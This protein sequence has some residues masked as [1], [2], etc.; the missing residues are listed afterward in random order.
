MRALPLARSVLVGALLAVTGGACSDDSEG[1]DTD[2]ALDTTAATGMGLPATAAGAQLAWVVT[3]GRTAD[4]A[5]ITERFS[6]GF[7]DEVP[8]DQLRSVLEGLG[9]LTAGEVRTS[10]PTSLQVLVTSADGP[11]FLASIAVEDASPHRIAGLRFEPA[12]LPVAPASWE[13]VDQR[14][15]ALAGRGAVFAAEVTGDGSLAVA[16]ERDADTVGPLGSAF[17]LYVLGALA[18]AVA[19]GA[20]AWDDQLTIE[21]ADR[22][23]PSGRLQDEVGS[24]V[25]VAEA[26]TL[27]I[28]I[29]DNTATDLLIRHLGRPTVEAVLEPMGLGPDARARTLPFLT[30]RELFT[31]KW[32]PDPAPLAA[33]AGA[34]EAQRRELL[35]E[36][37]ADLPAVGAV[38]PAVPVEIDRVEWF[39]SPRELAA[40]HVALEQRRSGASLEPLTAALGTN[41]GIAID[42]AVWSRTAFKGGS[43]PGV[44]TLSW[45]LERVDGRHFVL[46]LAGSDAGRAI[47]E[48]EG[49]AIATGAMA[50]LAAIP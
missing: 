38:D 31:L 33:Y 3:E 39:A 8:P 11:T 14:L 22:S 28:S 25:S 49:V 6:D 48:A 47:D 20:V 35:A 24:D 5:A 45:L 50:L 15:A 30:T 37:P 18:D 43:E 17:K 9:G 40:A 16:H 32:G 27:M 41:P 23:L 36:L 12:E 1:P 34:P 26:A 46:T 21:E 2:A 42:P 29:S 13:E 4:D 10:A 7:L 44:L 19:A